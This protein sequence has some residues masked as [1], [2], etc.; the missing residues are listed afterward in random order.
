MKQQYSLNELAK[1]YSEGKLQYDEYKR[2]RTILLK[3]IVSGKHKISQTDK[4]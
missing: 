4:K 3:D 2:L 1:K